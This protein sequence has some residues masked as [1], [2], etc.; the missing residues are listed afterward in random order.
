MK[1][2][3]LRVDKAVGPTS[4]DAVALARRALGTRRIGHTGTL[5]PFASGLLLLCIGNATRLA[6]YLTGLPKTYMAT[7][8]LGVRTDTD[9]RTGA[10]VSTSDA[11]QALGRAAIENA[12]ASQV[13]ERMQVPPA[14]S[15]KKIDGERMYARA[16]RGETVD[17]PPV[18]VNIHHIDVTRVEL[19]EVEFEV[20][21]SSGTY[22][23][24]IARDLGEALGVGA[25]L[26][27]LRR[28]GIGSFGLADAVTLDALTDTDAVARAWMTP[29][30]AVRGMPLH[31]ADA[32][33]AAALSHGRA[34]AITAEAG[35]SGETVAVEHGG[36]LLALATIDGAQL[37][38]RKVFP[39]A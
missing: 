7:A 38:P 28:T 1:D 9:D 39:D 2:G 19:P 25:H 31:H 5:D 34:A 36:R 22:I 13:G 4:H 16:R 6:E 24:S 12:L 23:R 18:A 14:Y 11:W 33:A 3:V 29:L 15:A 10:S 8:R 32:D 37:R 20:R 17:L 21:C 30:E 27:E 35:T 26:S